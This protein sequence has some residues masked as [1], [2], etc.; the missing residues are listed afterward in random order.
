MELRDPDDQSAV[1]AYC[2]VVNHN[3]K[4][5]GI[6]VSIVFDL[7]VHDQ[8]IALARAVSFGEAH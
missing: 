8:H 1:Y 4:P 7:A 2:V 3:E 5:L 6:V